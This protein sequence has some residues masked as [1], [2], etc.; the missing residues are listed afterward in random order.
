MKQKE[1]PYMNE[2]KTSPIMIFHLILMLVLLAFSLYS[3]VRIIG[4][5][6]SNTEIVSAN[7]TL[8]VLMYG[9]YKFL[10]AAALC[11]GMMYIW[12]GY[13]KSAASYYKAFL[14]L[15]ALATV[16]CTL[17]LVIMLQ[18]SSSYLIIIALVAHIVKTIAL[19]ILIFK[20]DLGEH[21]SWIL[22]GILIA[23]DLVIGMLTGD[24]DATYKAIR[25]VGL[26]SRLAMDVTIGLSIRGKYLDKTSRGTE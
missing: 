17:N 12:K 2:K 24:T 3:G 8:A 1:M 10:T 6:S 5:I 14:F 22:F 9:I 25:L 20:K 7:G 11:A 15:L 23:M 19:L 26:F 18:S 13:R 4:S 16:F 21:Y